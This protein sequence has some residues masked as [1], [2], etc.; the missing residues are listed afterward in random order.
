M[1]SNIGRPG[2]G[3][4]LGVFGVFSYY[5]LVILVFNIVPQIMKSTGS[6]EKRQQ[7]RIRSA[8]DSRRG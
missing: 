4:P 7:M 5:L 8:V 6:G 1:D 3:R 2:V